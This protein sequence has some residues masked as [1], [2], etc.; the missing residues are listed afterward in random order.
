LALTEEERM[1]RAGTE[2]IGASM[3]PGVK[4]LQRRLASVG[5]PVKQTGVV[6]SATVQAVN[7]IF[8]GWD[9]A[10]ANLSGGNLTAGQIAKNLGLVSKY[11]KKALGGAQNFGDSSKD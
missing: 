1:D 5:L 10:P 7:G 6:D 9:D 4:S 3:Q 8:A 2:K 11:V